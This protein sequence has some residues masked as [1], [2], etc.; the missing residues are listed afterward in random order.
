[1]I[2]KVTQGVERDIARITRENKIYGA[3]MLYLLYNNKRRAF[4]ETISKG[5]TAT[6]V[7]S[8]FAKHNDIMIK[9]RVEFESILNKKLEEYAQ[10]KGLFFPSE[11]VKENSEAK[12]EVIKKK[13]VEGIRNKSDIVLELNQ[14]LDA[15]TDIPTKRD[16][17]KLLV[18]VGNMKNENIE[19][20]IPSVVVLPQ[21]NNITLFGVECHVDPSKIKYLKEKESLLLDHDS[22]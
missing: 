3:C 19:T 1:M 22:K 6:N 14:L 4:D 7:T 10:V 9:A 11:A 21:K 2:A 18:D 5:T 16:L 13:L 20:A 12:M 15:T 8:Y 17:Y